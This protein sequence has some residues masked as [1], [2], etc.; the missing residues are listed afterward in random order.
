VKPQSRDVLDLLRKF[1]VSGI[2]Q[3]DA[4]TFLSCYR[5]AARIA[6]LR[7]EGYTIESTSETYQ[8]RR[9]A[10]YTLVPDPVQ[11]TLFFADAV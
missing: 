5:L 7:A 9:F 8:G 10:R 1:P 6:D 2:T 11:V 4:I 3:H